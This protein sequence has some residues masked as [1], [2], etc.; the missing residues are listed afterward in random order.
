M[1]ILLAGDLL[2]LEQ[3]LEALRETHPDLSVVSHSWSEGE[4]FRAARVE[5]PDLIV[6]DWSFRPRLTQEWAAYLSHIA[7]GARILAVYS[8]TTVIPA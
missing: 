3:A 5:Q 1:R 2:S 6:L 4:L 8:S 7:G